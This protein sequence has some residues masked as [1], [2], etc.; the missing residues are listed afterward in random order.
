[1]RDVNNDTKSTYSAT[2]FSRRL[3][4]ASQSAKAIVPWLVQSLKPCSIVDVGCGTGS[5]L[6]E[7]RQHGVLDLLGLDGDWVPR[8]GL[9]IP[10]QNFMAVNLAQPLRL[11]RHFDLAISLEVAEHLPAD[12]AGQFV[13]NLCSMGDVVLFSAAIPN[14]G[15]V[16]HLNEQWPGFW[17]EIF[18][19]LDFSC[20]DCIRPKYWNDER[21]AFWYAQNSFLFVRSSRFHKFEQLFEKELHNWAGLPLVHPRLLASTR[22]ALSNPNSY[23]VRGF[24]SALPRR[25][26]SRIRT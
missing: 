5:W 10:E 16:G 7:F 20:L 15:G 21:V 2:F 18:R 1:V 12:C 11:N 6:A 22:S 3:Q 24:F 23:S 17:I 13:Q 25:V 9:E 26:W 14:Q 19:H 4:K 8:S